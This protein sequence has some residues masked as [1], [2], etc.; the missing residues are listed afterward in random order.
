MVAD[1]AAY[2]RNNGKAVIVDAEHFF[3]GYLE[4]AG[5]SAEFLCLVVEQCGRHTG[6]VRHQRQPSCPIRPE[7]A[8]AAARALGGGPAR[9]CIS[10]T[11]GCAVANSVMA[12]LPGCRPRAGVYQRLRR[13]HGQ[14]RPHRCHSQ[15]QPQIGYR[16]HRGP[17]RLTLLTSGGPPHR[18]DRQPGPR[19][20][21]TLRRVVSLRPQSGDPHQRHRPGPAGRLPRGP[22]AVGNTTRFVLSEMSGRQQWRSR[23]TSSGSR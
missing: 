17:E 10:I 4:D 3:D 20:P 12:V 18:R 5:F 2:L 1:S 8:V 13:A 15:S 16:H 19:P 6:A 21:P 9:A 7:M 23:L 14:R 11:T 22:E